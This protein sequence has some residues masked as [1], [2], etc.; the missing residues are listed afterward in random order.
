ML[1]IGL[2]LGQASPRAGGVPAPST[3]PADW[4]MPATI[5]TSSGLSGSQSA[6]TT[7]QAAQNSKSRPAVAV[8]ASSTEWI[9]WAI[10]ASA[11][12]VV[13]SWIGAPYN[14]AAVAIDGADAGFTQKFPAGSGSD[15]P[16]DYAGTGTTKGG[17]RQHHLIPASASA[18]A[19]RLTITSG[20]GGNTIYPLLH[21]LPASGP[22]DAHVSL[23]AS[24]E[25]QGM[26]S[27][28]MEDA[29]IA[30]FPTRDPIVFAWGKSSANADDIAVYATQIAS[31]YAGVARFASVGAVI[32]N[33]WSLPYTSGQG[34]SLAPKQAAIVTTLQAAGIA[35]G[36]GNIS[37]RTT[38]ST[39]PAA[40]DNGSK[41][42][43]DNIVHPEI[44]TDAAAEYDGGYLR[45]R[46]DEYLLTLRY[47]GLLADDRHGSAAQ[48][49]VVSAFWADQWYRFVYT[50]AWGVPF[51]EQVTAAAE[52]SASTKATALINYTEAAYARDALAASAAK[53]AISARLAAIYP[54]V[55]FYEAVR[56]I[57]AA[58]ASPS[59]GTKDAAQAA[60]NAASAAGYSGGTAPNTIAAQQTRIDAI[61]LVTYAKVAQVGLGSNTAVA[62]WNRT[63]ATT[64]VASNVIA[65]L[66]QPAGTS[67]GWALNVTNAGTAPS[68]NSAQTSAMADFPSAILT[69]NAPDTANQLEL[70]V[71]GLDNGK[72]Y[73]V[74]ATATRTGVASRLT[75]LTLNG[76]V[77]GDIDVA[78]NVSAL[79]SVQGVSPA[80]GVIT[81]NFARGAGAS[82]CYATAFII[83]ERV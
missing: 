41:P 80:S 76:V 26:P 35:V 59:Q 62:G 27:R 32:T 60:L 31:L 55:L 58:E 3:P 33:S 78:N 49:D 19:V 63:N 42:Y 82:T 56:V 79:W 66:L 38:N 11:T 81:L 5:T 15:L 7:A 28:F 74:L 40:Q 48:Y 16:G 17:R 75:R 70:T 18:R 2:G 69:G 50:G 51:I 72:L 23:G 12:P 47:R 22:W 39:T 57:D 68:I 45:A 83:K 73:D 34:A 44:S 67:T 54:T 14:G 13:L 24:R 9:E 10:P 71:S 37:F 77:I 29:I 52:G 43:N 53:T 65:D 46:I 8:P 64:A 61:V 1:G 20:A 30:A 36:V 21:Q 6:L 4:R 25:D